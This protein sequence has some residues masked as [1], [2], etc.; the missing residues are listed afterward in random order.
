[1][2]A[3]RDGRLVRTEAFEVDRFDDAMARLEEL[4]RTGP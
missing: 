1:M 2:V 4:H 3:D